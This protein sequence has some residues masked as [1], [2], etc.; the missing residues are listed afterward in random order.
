MVF[1]FN[2]ITKCIIKN[3][4]VSPQANELAVGNCLLSF[5]PPLSVRLLLFKIHV[6]IGVNAFRGVHKKSHVFKFRSHPSYLKEIC[7]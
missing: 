7:I 1:C 2:V 6:F 3:M 5:R 4:Y